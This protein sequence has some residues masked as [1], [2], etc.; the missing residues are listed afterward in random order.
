MNGDGAASRQLFEL[1]RA[2]FAA[3]DIPLVGR[4]MKLPAFEDAHKRGEF[5]LYYGGWS[6]DYPDPENF[7]QLLYGKNAAPGSNN[8]S[9]VDPGYDK[10]Y[11]AMRLMGNGPERLDHVRTMNRL[12]HEDV[13]L[14][15]IYETLHFTVFQK[16]VRNFKNGLIPFEYMYLGLDAIPRA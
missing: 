11:E 13:P 8:G 12:I 4:F 14:L 5:Q 15:F 7:F 10:A 6:E 9:Y 1:L 2:Q 3:A 16:R